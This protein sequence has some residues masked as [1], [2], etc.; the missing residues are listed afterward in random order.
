LSLIVGVIAGLAYGLSAFAG[1]FVALPLLVLVVGIELHASL[2]VALAGLALCAAVAAGDAARA[3][4]CNST[5]VLMAVLG[6][7]PVAIA[8]AWLAQA[9]PAFVLVSIF[10]LAAIAGG[11]LLVRSGGGQ[12][13]PSALWHAPR[14]PLTEAVTSD[15]YPAAVQLRAVCAGAANALLAALC[16]AGGSG[17]VRM[18]D[19]SAP[20]Q[21]T[22]A[23][24]T[25]VLVVA[26]LAATAATPQ[27]MLAPTI[28]G[29]TAGLYVLGTVAGMGFARRLASLRVQYWA[30]RVIAL[31]VVALAVLLWLRVAI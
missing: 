18:A 13:A 2:P 25:A 29:Y 22:L 19:R 4:Q 17:I 1:A 7:L 9:L 3:R 5:L 20:G 11:L 16:A 6:G 24:G 27:L 15:R 12:I 26:V 10:S 23:A 31:L 30:E 14:R 8:A 21:N 28:P